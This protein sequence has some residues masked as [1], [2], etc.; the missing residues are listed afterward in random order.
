MGCCSVVEQSTETASNKPAPGWAKFLARI[1]LSLVFSLIGTG[2]LF[3]FGQFMFWPSEGGLFRYKYLQWYDPVACFI[4]SWVASY[5]FLHKPPMVHPIEGALKVV[6]QVY[7]II[8]LANVLVALPDVLFGLEAAAVK[9][10]LALFLTAW[11]VTPPGRSHLN[12]RKN[13][14]LATC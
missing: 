8:A 10:G 6:A 4:G 5:Y 9:T 1:G 2:V 11:W 7:A 14:H 3:A 13:D 12:P